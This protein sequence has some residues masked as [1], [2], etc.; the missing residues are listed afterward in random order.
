MDKKELKFFSLRSVMILLYIVVV[1][2]IPLALRA[3]IVEYN[4]P[5]ETWH[6][7]ASKT[8]PEVF[9]QFRLELLLITTV[10]IVLAA[11]LKLYYEYDKQQGITGSYLDYPAA[12]FAFLVVLS[13]LLSPYVNLAFWG[14]YNRG[15][16]SF[17]YLCYIFIFIVA[18][19]F[20]NAEKDKKII[21][22]AAIVAGLLHSCIAVAQFFGFE[23]LRSSLA[24]R[25]FIP[26][27]YLPFVEDIQFQFSYKGAGTTFN[28]NYMGG[29]MAMIFPVVFVMYLYSRT[30]REKA[31]WLV[32]LLISLA[33]FFAPTSIGAF[34]SGGLALLVFFMLTAKDIK[35]YYKNLV[36]VLLI[37]AVVAGVSEVLSGGM[38]SRKVSNFTER[39]LE[40]ISDSDLSEE[41]SGDFTVEGKK[42][43][44][45]APGVPA[46]GT[47]NIE[48][49][50]NPYDE[51][52]NG[53]YYIWRKSLEVIKNNFLIG[54]GL[55]TFLYNFPNWDPGRYT[56]IGV[57]VDKPHNTYLQIA[58]GAG[59]PALLV[60]IYMLILHF[61]NYLRVFRRRGLQEESDIIMLALFVGWLGYLFQGL[62]NDSV[63]SNA[64]VFWALFGLSV[65]YVKNALVE[66]EEKKKSRAVDGKH[67]KEADLKKARQ[68]YP[69]HTKRKK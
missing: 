46:G 24:M 22:Y 36:S 32:A 40:A 9:A 21:F 18:A 42:E 15:E 53:R 55:D 16:G 8:I 45:P 43:K 38:I 68:Q 49:H 41:Q 62:G 26:G 4:S 47:I 31:V 30:A 29:Y 2:I 34:I 25:L 1:A 67:L 12:V 19:I 37:V 6:R 57:L 33:G 56:R 69:K 65:N 48:I 58:M 13:G 60:Y 27:A 63:L 64:P 59:V 44:I 51:L 3:R 20:I 5:V 54:T 61:K 7:L 14:Y 28:P 52:G 10:L 50:R 35:S 11:L 17:A 66:I 39:T 23:P